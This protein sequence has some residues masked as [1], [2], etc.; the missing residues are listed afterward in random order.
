MKGLAGAG[1]LA[2]LQGVGR[3]GQQVRLAG[4][5][6]HGGGRINIPQTQAVKDRLSKCLHALTS[7]RRYGDG[8]TKTTSVVAK[9]TE[10]FPW[11]FVV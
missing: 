6:R 10:G 2:G 8:G 4:G 1:G 7:D 9:P 5:E 11:V 3:L